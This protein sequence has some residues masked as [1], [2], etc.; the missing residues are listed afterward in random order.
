MIEM[1]ATHLLVDVHGVG[2]EIEIPLSTYARIVNADTVSLHTHLVVREDAQLLYGF[3]TAGERELFRALIKVNRVGPKLALTIMSGMEASAL[4]EY[5]HN[6]DA[7]S[8]S[9][10]PGVGKKTAEQM[11][12]DL[13]GKLPEFL[14]AFGG[15]DANL[16]ASS[17]GRFADAESALI[18]L[19]F[20]PQEAAR[21]LST[22]AD[23]NA[24]VA[25]LIKQALKALG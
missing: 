4:A 22:V 6:E 17:S 25:S 23:E 1:G 16:P 20:K 15:N 14:Q 19:G 13:R 21:A 3:S 18:G 5:I 9:A 7:G 8:L 24:D 10:L 12:I 2:Y 11:I